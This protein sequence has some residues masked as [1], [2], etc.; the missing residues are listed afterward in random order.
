LESLQEEAEM[1][2]VQLQKSR[3]AVEKS[4]SMSGSSDLIEEL[5]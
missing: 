4:S 2:K 5:K 3:A 1:L